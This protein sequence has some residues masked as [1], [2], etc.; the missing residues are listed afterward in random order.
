MGMAKT[1]STTDP[2]ITS[3]NLKSR[4]VTPMF[5]EIL[6]GAMKLYEAYE[7]ELK[8]FRKYKCV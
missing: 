4:M 1:Y 2:R 6:E 8:C 5:T 7:R 3:D